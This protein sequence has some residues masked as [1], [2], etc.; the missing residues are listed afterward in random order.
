LVGAIATMTAATSAAAA[1]TSTSPDD[2]CA[3]QN[4]R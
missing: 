1:I 4:G 3:Q 2:S